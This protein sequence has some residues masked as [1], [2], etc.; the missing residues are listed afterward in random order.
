MQGIFY[1]LRPVIARRPKADAAI[2]IKSLKC[3]AGTAALDCFAP[4]AMTARAM[5]YR[6]ARLRCEPSPISFASCERACA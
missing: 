3:A 2:Q 5:P 1:C 4:L 6:R